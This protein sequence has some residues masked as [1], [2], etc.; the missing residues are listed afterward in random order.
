MGMTRRALW[1]ATA[2]FAAMFATFAAQAQ[3]A[4][5]APADVKLV[6]RGYGWLLTDARGMSLYTYTADQEE[7]RSACVAA[8]PLM[9]PALVAPADAKPQGEW[10]TVKLE[11]GSLQWA[12]RH[13]PLY[14][15][16][17][18]SKPQDANGDAY[19]EKWYVAIREIA[20]PP[21]FRIVKTAEGH[22]LVDLQRM[23]LYTAAADK[24]GKSACNGS[25]VWQWRPVEAPWVAQMPSPD[26]NTITRADGTRQWA[27]KGQPLY[28][29]V[30]DFTVGDKFGQNVSGHKPVVL[31]PSPGV[32][33][34]VTV[35]KSDGG[36]LYA[37]PKGMTLY[38]HDFVPTVRQ[39]GEG[40]QR[41]M[42]WQPVLATANDKP[43]G[44][45]SIVDLPDGTKQWVF[46]GMRIY[47]NKR[48][49]R[50]GELN[51]V[52]STDRV[53]M[54]LMTNGQ[55]MPGTGS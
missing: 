3:D 49:S 17:R 40:I 16:A 12:F 45:W 10:S 38:A 18:D 8:C 5:A 22:V 55:T 7:G 13:K 6:K 2:L 46:K 26:W 39:A 53:W 20:M 33:S 9:W 25:C 30:E 29:F 24:G 31:E 48:D 4:P 41:P 11:D 27:Y 23:T 34:W 51:G 37:D 50:P 15:H 54:P 43:V 28:R 36:E 44:A 19:D 42:D 1:L 52:R 47:V 32:P 14:T 21:G 35:Q